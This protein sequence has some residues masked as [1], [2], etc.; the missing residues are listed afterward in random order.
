VSKFGNVRTN[1]FA[2][3]REAKRYEELTWLEKAGE[4]RDLKTQVGFDLHVKDTKV[5]RYIA[6][7]TYTT[8]HG[9]T[10]VEDSKGFRTPLYQLKKKML[11][12]EYGI[13]ILET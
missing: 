4:I 3:K 5:S 7:F 1:G 2:S 6:D 13:V 10:V 11:A 9:T 8:S 12:A